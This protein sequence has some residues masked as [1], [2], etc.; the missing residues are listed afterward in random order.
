MPFF[1]LGKT[2]IPHR[3]STSS[4]PPVR[5]QS[6]SGV[7]IPLAQHIGAPAK[8][9]CKVGD[10]VFVGTL[11]A[12][13]GGYVSANI[14]SSV[15]GVVKKIDNLLQS[16]GRTVGCIFIESDGKME[17]DPKIKPPVID[18]LETLSEA[19]KASGLVGLG[20]AGFPTH[21]KIDGAKGG[22]IDRIV[23]NAAE[24]EPYITSDTRTMLDDTA[25][26]REGIELLLRF[27]DAQVII[28]IENNKPEAIEKLTG[29]LSDNERVRIQILSDKYPQG[30]EKILIY[31]TSCQR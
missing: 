24:C 13:A 31:I 19:V 23:I 11:I 16:S 12:E 1:K 7:K 6:V 8:P 27:I 14:H 21:V 28:G 20:G 2:R 25:M 18:S 17:L 15:S 29:E 26:I 4:M 5:I 30:A 10:H 3:K 22:K 9:V